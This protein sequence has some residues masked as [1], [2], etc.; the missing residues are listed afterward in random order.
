M[1][2]FHAWENAESDLFLFLC[3]VQQVYDITQLAPAVI[4]EGNDACL[5]MRDKGPKKNDRTEIREAANKPIV[6][7]EELRRPT[8]Q[9]GESRKLLVVQYKT[10]EFME[11]QQDFFF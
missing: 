7:L 10:G 6:T 8:A 2:C 11:E 1:W 5:A 3:C 4:W 9:L